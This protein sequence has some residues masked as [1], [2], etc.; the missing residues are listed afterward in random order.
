MR[1]KERF[2]A[3]SLAAALE[4]AKAVWASPELAGPE[5]WAALGEL[6]AE[7]FR[8][9]RE[10]W[11]EERLW[12]ADLGLLTVGCTHKKCFVGA[13]GAWN[14]LPGPD[15]ELYALAAAHGAACLVM[16]QYGP[17]TFYE[18]FAPRFSKPHTLVAGG[19][20]TAS[21]FEMLWLGG[22]LLGL[23]SGLQ[24][25]IGRVGFLVLYLGGAF[26]VSLFAA[27]QRHSSTGS[28][29]ALAS[30]AYHVLAAP[31]ARHNIFGIEM[32]ARMALAVHF[33]IS[34]WP[35]LNGSTGRPLIGLALNGLPIVFGGALWWLRLLLR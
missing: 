23:G 14:S 22:T 17:N 24:R 7:R 33:G 6:A 18:H 20:A 16:H 34:T 5:R 35:S 32:G 31:S 10:Q 15:A 1:R 30:F 12:A 29:G 19:F 27:S 26:G 3:G 8:F 13:L 4:P 2:G 9:G 11:A 25:A 28:G 21:P